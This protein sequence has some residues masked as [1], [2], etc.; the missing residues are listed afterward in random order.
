MNLYTEG[1]I[2][3]MEEFERILNC[4]AMQF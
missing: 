2:D 3:G 1:P 4:V